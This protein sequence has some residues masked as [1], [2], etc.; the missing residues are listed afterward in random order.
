MKLIQGDD[1]RIRLN[2]RPFKWVTRCA[3]LL[4]VALTVISAA[5]SLAQS[6]SPDLH[7]EIES[8]QMQLDLL[9]ATYGLEPTS[10][11]ESKGGSFFNT[12]MSRTQPAWAPAT[13]WQCPPVTPSADA[14]YPTANLT[15][16]FQADAG[17][18]H[19]SPGNIA[20]VGDAQDGADFRRARLAATGDVAENVSYMLEMD[21]AFP[22]RP[23]FMDVWLQ[24]QDVG[25]G[26]VRIGQFRQPIGM[27]GQTGVK[28]LTFLERGLPAAFLPFRQIG[29]MYFGQNADET[30]TWA[31]SG[32]RFPT[33]FFGGNVGDNGGYGM[34]SRLTGLLIDNGDDGVVH[35]GAGYT[36]IDPANDLVQYRNQPE[37]FV[38]ETGGAALVPPGV[39][40]NLPFFVDTGLLPTT[41]VNLVNGEL[42]VSQGSFYA[43][44]EIY[45]AKVNQMGG[46]SL[47]F[48]GAYVQ[49]AWILTGE[50][51]PYNRKAGVF[52]RVVPDSPFGSDGC[53][54][55]EAAARL[56]RIDLNDANIQGGR[57]NDLTLGLNWYVNKYTKFQFNYIHAMLGSSSATP[58]PVINSTD[59]NIFAIRAQVDF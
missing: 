19:Q 22:G 42:G 29:M 53:G 24:L 13:G 54:A 35:V 15:G 32:F 55:W 23:S 44:S 12:G 18:I 26:N 25:P 28:E 40:T 36:F 48:S 58:G 16:F 6:E 14:N 41:N 3:G 11:T 49:A 27:D 31:M 20:A 59:A 50:S 7:A 30:A 51:R 2:A 9:K 1:G 4:V 21:F 34:A 57:L 17:W 47:G 46:P 38:A 10:S 33:D 5:E 45:Y 56:S 52:G 8:L 37:F 39:P 43:Q